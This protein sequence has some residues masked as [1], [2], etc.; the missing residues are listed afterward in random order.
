MHYWRTHPEAMQFS[1]EKVL[2][3]HI[4]VC[5]VPSP[6][7]EAVV[8]NHIESRTPIV[9]EGDYLLPETLEKMRNSEPLQS[10]QVKAV[11]L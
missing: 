11:F 3:W 7:V 6:A 2:Q 9:L 1:V 10:E 4:A 8:A 5:R